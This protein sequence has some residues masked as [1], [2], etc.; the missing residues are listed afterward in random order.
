VDEYPTTPTAAGGSTAGGSAAGRDEGGYQSGDEG[1]FET[2]RSSVSYR[3]A[4]SN[5]ASEGSFKS[6]RSNVQSESGSGELQQV[7]LVSEVLLC[8]VVSSVRLDLG[9]G[10]H[11]RGDEGGCRSGEER[12]VRRRAAV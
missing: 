11:G 10:V 3:S 5:P 1:G 8:F 2:P 9:V 6:V 7:V 12:G 4:Q